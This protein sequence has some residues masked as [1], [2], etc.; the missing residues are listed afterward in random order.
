MALPDIGGKVH[1]YGKNKMS[2][3]SFMVGGAYAGTALLSACSQPATEVTGELVKLYHA[4]KRFSRRARYLTACITGIL[5][6]DARARYRVNGGAWVPVTHEK[7]RMPRP[8]FTVEM[9]KSELKRGKNLVEI[10]AFIHDPAKEKTGRISHAFDYDD[11]E[12]QLPIEEHWEKESELDVQEG[13]W[14]VITTPNADRRLRPRPQHE[15][16]DR[17]VCASGA[18]SGG[19]RVETEVIYRNRVLSYKPFGFGLIPLWGGRPDDPAVRPLRGWTFAVA[20]YYSHY[21]GVGVEMSHKAGTGAPRW[22][23]SYRNMNLKPGVSYRIITEAWPVR[24]AAGKHLA[25]HIRMLWHGD[26]VQSDWIQISDRE[27]SPMPEGDYS[28]A[29]L[30]HRCQV[31]FGSVKIT[32]LEPAIEHSGQVG[33]PPRG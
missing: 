26:G 1:E 3:R 24:D 12:I 31:E 25:Y 4:P 30:A 21:R 16:Y 20:W 13:Y 28:V 6:Q 8:W 10:E 17:I 22:I 29:V 2:R 15:W 14:E 27:G 7:N 33:R 11:A 18:F 9:A 5:R 19:R 23:T 32:A